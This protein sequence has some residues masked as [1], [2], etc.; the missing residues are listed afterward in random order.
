MTTTELIVA[1][2]EINA[3]ADADMATEEERIAGSVAAP[4]ALRARELAA[5]TGAVNDLV[6][7]IGIE[8]ILTALA[9]AAECAR[10]TH[11]HFP[12]AAG[13][14]RAR[15]ARFEIALNTALGCVS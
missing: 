11:E 13:S 6:R 5:H 8:A 1:G 7:E 9:R 12:S 2:L 10:E 14:A 15:V 4:D 3:E